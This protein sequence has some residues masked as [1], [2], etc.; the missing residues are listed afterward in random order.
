[1]VEEVDDPHE[2]DADHH[3]LDAETDQTIHCLL[4]HAGIVTPGAD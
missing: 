3:G 2:R 4:A 1:M